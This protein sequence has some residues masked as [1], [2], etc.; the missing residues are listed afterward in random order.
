MIELDAL[1]PIVASFTTKG[2]AK[3]CA[4][5]LQALMVDHP[6]DVA[7]RLQYVYVLLQQRRVADARHALDEVLAT[8]PEDAHVLRHVAGLLFGVGDFDLARDYIRRAREAL[9][10]DD[11]LSRVALTYLDGMLAAYSGEDD[12][13]RM[14]LATA[15]EQGQGH[16]QLPRYARSLLSL[17]VRQGDMSTARSLI[18]KLPE[19]L[20]RD[21]LWRMV[22]ASADTIEARR[23]KYEYEM[24]SENRETAARAGYHL[25]L[26]LEGADPETSKRA[27]QSAIDSAHEPEASYSRVNLASLLE[28]TDP[29][30]AR[31]LYEAAVTS[32]N[33]GVRATAANNL[34]RLLTPVDPVGASSAYRMALE[35]GDLTVI[36]GAALNLGRLTEALGDASAAKRVYMEAID[37][38]HGPEAG[39]AALSLGLLLTDVDSDSAD[40]AFR[41]AMTSPDPG[42]AAR[43]ALALGLLHRRRGDCDRGCAALKA[44][45]SLGG[46]DESAAAA[47]LLLASA[48]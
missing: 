11:S 2:R 37:R 33:V 43:A 46:D 42:E 28:E 27:Y 4:D 31:V 10:P 6:D 23:R 30:A 7:L 35:T 34:G 41:K 12:R 18:S 39:T 36:P 8:A 20:N 38:L 25:G 14:L 45:M 13:A 26:L 5:F 1:A 17:L 19:D 29:C 9:D 22:E 16:P 44:A 15:V 32:S 3:E 24:A 48:P 21:E 47:R 40:A